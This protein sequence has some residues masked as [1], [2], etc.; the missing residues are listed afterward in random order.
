MFPALSES[1]GRTNI[2]QNFFGNRTV[3]FMEL[4]VPGWVQRA[5]KFCSDSEIRDI[6]LILQVSEHKSSNLVQV[7]SGEA[8]I[9]FQAVW[10][11]I[12]YS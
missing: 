8:E 6:V 2:L 10:L 5:F 12:A 3:I 4:C 9:C 7:I 1:N 11:H